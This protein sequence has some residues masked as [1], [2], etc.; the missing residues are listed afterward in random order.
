MPRALSEQGIVPAL[1]QLLST[2]FRSGAV[3]YAFEHSQLEVELPKELE[4]ILYRIAQELLNNVVKHSRANHVEV[5]LYQTQKQ[6]VLHVEDNGIGFD[7]QTGSGHGM[8]NIRNR[9]AMF[10]GRLNIHSGEKE[11]TSITASFPKQL[12]EKHLAA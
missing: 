8:N 1:E 7:E 5:Q 9:V 11:G 10:D 3:N 4:V 12:L 6:L 2:S